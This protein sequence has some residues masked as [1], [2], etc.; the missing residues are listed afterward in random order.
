MP[1]KKKSDTDTSL[2]CRIHIDGHEMNIFQFEIKKKKKIMF[3]RI[4]I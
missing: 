3:I 2:A 4:S 1:F